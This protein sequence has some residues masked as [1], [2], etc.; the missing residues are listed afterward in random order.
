MLRISG[1][2]MIICVIMLFR[3]MEIKAL[4]G[5]VSLSI[6]K[7]GSDCILECKK[8][9]YGGAVNKN[10]VSNDCKCLKDD[11]AI[12]EPCYDMWGPKG[13]DT[14]T[15]ACE[16]HGFFGA[17]CFHWGFGNFLKPQCR[18]QVKSSISNEISAIW[19]VFGG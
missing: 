2:F 8:S 6:C 15:P 18:C 4:Y 17:R 13:K 19:K 1:I 16:K 11:I 7:S 14:C 12:E 9:G 10:C 3:V 5:E